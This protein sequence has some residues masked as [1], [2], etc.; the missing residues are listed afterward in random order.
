MP[1]SPRRH[2]LPWH[3]PLLPQAVAHLAG[4]WSGDGPLDL[5][6]TLVVVPTRQSGR[7]LREAIAA[8]AARLRAAAFP[9]RVFTPDGLLGAAAVPNQPNRVEKLLGWV[10]VLRAIDLA[11]F[12]DVFPIDPPARDFPW[13]LRLAE[14]L[15]RLQSTLAE[16]RLRIRDVAPKAS[17]ADFPETDRWRQLGTLEALQEAALTAAGVSP[18]A[19][20]LPDGW[21][22]LERIVVVA[23]PDPIPAAITLLENLAGERPVDVLIFAPRD[24]AGR[25]DSWGRPVEAEWS[26]RVLELSDFEQRVQVCA[27]PA[28][29][30]SRI[31]RLAGDYGFGKTGGSAFA[32]DGLLSIG[33]ADPEVVPLLE[34]EAARAAVPVFNPEGHSRRNGGLYHLLMALSAIARSPTFEAVEALARCPDFL[35]YLEHG[36]ETKFSPAQ[37][38]AGLDDLRRRHLPGDLEAARAHA[39]GLVAHTLDAMAAIR[40]ELTHREFPQSIMSVLQQIFGG[41]RLALARVEDADLQDAASAWRDEVR[42]CAAAAA[43]FGGGVSPD[44]IWE[45]ALR[46]FGDSVRTEDKPAGALELQGWLELLFEDAPHLVIAGLNDGFVPEA[47]SEDPFLPESLRARL[48]LKTNG[49]RF[50]RDAYLL[51][52]LAASRSRLG[53][54]DLLLAKNSAAGDPLRPS[55][56]LLRCADAE[57]PRRVEYLFGTPETEGSHLPWM[58]AWRLAPR[59]VPAPAKVAVTALRRWLACP[60]RFYLKSVLRMEAVDASKSEMD[61][62]D[63]GTLCHAAFEAMGREPAVR[64]C[65]DAGALREFLLRE[66]ARHVHE[67]FGTDLPLPLLIQVESA[68]QRLA[69]VAELQAAE[70]AAG[71]VIEAVERPFAIEIGGL[72]VNG[73]ID[74]IDRNQS[75][76]SVRVLDYKT[77]DTAVNPLSAHLKPVP[78]DGTTLPEWALVNVD[79][80]LRAW[81]DLQLPLYRHALAPEWGR[82]IGCGY[83]NV[84]KAVGQTALAL[85]EDE[86]LELQESAMRCAEGVC[87]AIRRGEFWP[88]NE[89]VRADADEFAALFHRGVAAS[90]D[91]KAGLSRTDESP[92]AAAETGGLA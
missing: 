5:S 86:T 80:R 40:E 39:R 45:V 38:L 77:S 59:I 24:E 37:C 19:W 22:Q 81:A 87:A 30:A 75:T 76:G 17:G 55:R 89:N 62:F 8:H 91:F 29:Q 2:F 18:P 28:D 44:E 88:P 83:I 14:R 7:R 21:E 51:Q 60:F 90:V 70:R 92:T 63:F 31:A 73:K 27:D 41:R 82:A 68:R 1:I 35:T 53:R 13:A 72:V 50:S 65:T 23:T 64:D 6:D 78:R 20:T 57:L 56:L 34:G 58:R 43:R 36:S 79:G 33:V 61:A 49:A 4:G 11:E 46:L 48:G 25:F 26:S 66:L 3:T 9:P 74:R 69:K 15:L 84:P 10:K 42:V 85:W 32:P 67:R 52:A 47:V 71:W 12:R 16:N 54:V